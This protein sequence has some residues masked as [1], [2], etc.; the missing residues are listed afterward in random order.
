MAGAVASAGALGSA[1]FAPQ[2]ARLADQRGQR[3]VLRPLVTAFA[4]ATGGLIAAVELHA[5]DWV[6]FIP[7]V[8]SGATMPSLGSMVR[9][10]WSVLLAGSPQLHTAFSFE[11]VAD[12]M[13][14]VLGPV[15]VTLL[16][17]EVYPPAGLL[18]ATVLCVAGVLWFV[19]QRSTEPPATIPVLPP[20][21]AG[22]RRRGAAAPALLVLVPVYWCLGAMFVSVDLSTVAFA[23]HFGHKPLAGFVLGTYALGSA[24]GG[25]WYGTR[26]WRARTE[27]RFALTLALTVCGVSTF[28]AQPSLLTLV[29]VMYLCGLTIAPTL[30]AGYSLAQAQARPGRSTEA[31]TWLST[32]IAVGV[33]AGSSVVGFIID[34]H[35]ARWGYVFAAGCGTACVL[36]CLAGLRRLG[37]R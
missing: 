35:G 19:A 10:R 2:V 8:V 11:S 21:E 16:A 24:T 29:P 7:A 20:P 25:L 36:L 12:E 31:M 26:T 14:F 27:R 4:I 17:T 22:T 9:A 23:Q 37:Q 18:V 30:I 3:T 34:A 5:P 13:V 33:A 32:G 15:L 6:L 1:F 28:W